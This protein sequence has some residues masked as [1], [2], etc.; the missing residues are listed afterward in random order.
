[1]IKTMEKKCTH[2][3]KEL[4]NKRNIVVHINIHNNPRL[5]FFCSKE[6]KVQWIYIIQRDN[7]VLNDY[8]ENYPNW[9]YT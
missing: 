5:R 9:S 8:I 3:S 4:K 6:C 2:C 1:M 7:K